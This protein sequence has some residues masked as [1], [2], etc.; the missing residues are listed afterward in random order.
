MKKDSGNYTSR[1]F[2]DDI[3]TDNDKGSG[4]PA[5]MFVEKYD[6]E[7]FTNLLIVCND[8]RRAQVDENLATMM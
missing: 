3:Y 1:D 4:I 5:E 2:T 8:E 7:M 6:S